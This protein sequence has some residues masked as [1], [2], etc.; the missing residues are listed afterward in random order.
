MPIDH[1]KVHQQLV[2]YDS[3]D[4]AHYVLRQQYG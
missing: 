1:S 4:Q 2:A 3:V